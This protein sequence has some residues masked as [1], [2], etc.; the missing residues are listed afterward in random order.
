MA[1]FAAGSRRMGGLQRRYYAG[2][3]HGPTQLPV[4]V[5]DEQHSD[6][7]LRQTKPGSQSLLLL[8]G[9]GASQITYF[10]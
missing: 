1:L 2:E 9:I 3:G 7:T 4:T 8:Q 5:P 10:W 6:L